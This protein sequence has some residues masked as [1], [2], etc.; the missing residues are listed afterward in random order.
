[1]VLHARPLVFWFT[2]IANVVAGSGGL[3]WMGYRL[4]KYEVGANIVEPLLYGTAF[5]LIAVLISAHKAGAFRG[6]FKEKQ[7][8][9]PNDSSIVAGE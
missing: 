2:G 1:M 7:G 3:S 6:L 9:A 8:A 5:F 4:I